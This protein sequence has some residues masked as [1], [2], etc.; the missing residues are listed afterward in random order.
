MIDSGV[1]PIRTRRRMQLATVASRLKIGDIVAA[2]APILIVILGWWLLTT[3]L[4]R[5]RIFP[6]PAVIWSELVLILAGSSELGNSYGHIAATMYR[7]SVAFASALVIGTLLGVVAGR[8]RAVFSLLENVVWICMAVPSIVW[9]FIFAVTF[10]LS[11]VVPIAAVAALLTPGVIINVAEG[12]KSIPSDILQMSASYKAGRWQ[13][14]I[15]VYLP[16][17]VPYVASSARVAFALGIKLIVVAEVVGIPN[18]VGFEVK[19]WYDQL[20][21]APMIAWGIVMITI[22]FIVDH[23]LFGTIER[24]VGR[25]KGSSQATVARRTL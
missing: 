2:T 11:D 15:D 4:D 7:L 10:G 18:G 14:L 6:S 22:G 23:G 1:Q 19:Y 24:R 12:S 9:V 25:W 13:R 21:M 5:P 3:T 20:V 16:F 8:V 17:L